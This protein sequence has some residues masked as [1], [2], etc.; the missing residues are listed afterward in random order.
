[1][2]RGTRRRRRN[3]RRRRERVEVGVVKVGQIVGTSV[4]TKISDI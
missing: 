3:R 2:L 1:M 4:A